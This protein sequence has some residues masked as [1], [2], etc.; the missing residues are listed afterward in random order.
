MNSI[1]H[2]VIGRRDRV[3]IPKWRISNL[4]AKV[5]TGAYGSA[6]H[7]HHIEL[8][9]IDG[10]EVLR[11]KLL[12]PNHP[13]YEEQYY[14]AQQYTNKGVKSSS[15]ELQ[16]RY[17]IKEEI[18]L[19]GIAYETEFSLTDRSEMKYPILLGRKFL[20]KRFLV[21]VSKINIYYKNSQ[22]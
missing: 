22:K 18:V 3:D 13:E 9:E 7:C 2:K 14:Y 5:D 21:D 19:D 17:V 10:K 1:K 11:F 6:M 15:G 16:N 4:E 12:D 20:K 8:T